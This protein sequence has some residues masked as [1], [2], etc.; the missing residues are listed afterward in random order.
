LD[1]G[2]AVDVRAMA[3]IA[4]RLLD[5]ERAPL[6]LDASLADLAGA[7][8]LP[9]WYD[10]WVLLAQERIR[11]LRLHALEALALRLASVG[12][13]GEAVDAA[14]VAVQAEPLRES[15]HRTL[16]AVHLGEGNQVEAL[17][18]YHRYRELV[19]TALGANPSAKMEEL[20]GAACAG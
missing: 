1:A 20:V 3:T 9:D 11:Q 15:A 2:V 6:P 17:R 4:A 8:L 16:I 5:P 13:Y 7:E 19:H 14:L 10:D 18:H 12:R